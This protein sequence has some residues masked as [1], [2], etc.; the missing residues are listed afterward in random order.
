LDLI[1]IPLLLAATALLTTNNNRILQRRAQT[2]ILVFF[3]NPFY[4]MAREV[5]KFSAALTAMLFL[6]FPPSALTTRV[7]GE[8]ELQSNIPIPLG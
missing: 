8:E 3:P 2:L 5:L 7:R 1:D 4:K 6:S